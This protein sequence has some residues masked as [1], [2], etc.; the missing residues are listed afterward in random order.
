MDF[1]DT[2]SSHINSLQVSTYN[3]TI[4]DSVFFCDKYKTKI[5]VY[6][7]ICFNAELGLWLKYCHI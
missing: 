4:V 1:M 3:L 2:D 6:F 5:G 7:M